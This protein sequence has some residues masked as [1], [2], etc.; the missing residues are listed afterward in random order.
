MAKLT[1]IS[2]VGAKGPACFLVESGGARLLLDLGYGPD[3]G[4]WPDVGGTGRVVA[5][6]LSH[7]H[8]DH[9]GGL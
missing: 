7:G 6:L 4:Q 9:A 3:P 8:R 1:A 2:G 5:L